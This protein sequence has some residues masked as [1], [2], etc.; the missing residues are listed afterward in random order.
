MTWPGTAC[1]VDQASLE[2]RALLPSA[3]PALELK[4]ALPLLAYELLLSSDEFQVP[5]QCGAH[6]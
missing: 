3:F 4:D 5:R 2:L 6:R 1:S